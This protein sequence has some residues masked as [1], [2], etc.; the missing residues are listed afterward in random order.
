MKSNTI[1]KQEIEKFSKIASQWWDPNGKFK[2]LHKFNPIRIRYIKDNIIKHFKIKS[3]TKPLKRINILDI[4]CGGG[5]LSE[6]MCRLGAN[7]VGIDASKKNIETAKFHAKK[8]NLKINY[9]CSSPEIL[10]TRK[11]FD[12]ILNMEI[13]EHV[14]DVNFFIKK[15]SELLKKNGLMFVATLNKTLK[16]YMFAIVGAEYILQWLPIGTHDWERFVRPED[17][18]KISKKNSLEL[19]NL[20]G[21][22]FDIF[23]NKWDVSG[24][25]SVNYI[26]NFKKN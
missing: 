21:L 2:P 16:S 23:S 5:L 13:V 4:G 18:I 12:V 20:D 7:V 25:N 17:L 1:N 22:K 3:S 10:K 9:I 19:K 6:P 14:E 8:N 11:K 24:D 26:A 15:S